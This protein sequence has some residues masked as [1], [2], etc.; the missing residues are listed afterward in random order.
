MVAIIAWLIDASRRGLLGLGTA[1]AVLAIGAATASAD[2]ASSPVS[3]DPVFQAV[4]VDGSSPSGRI[5]SFDSD[6]ITIATKEGARERLA[7]D[8]LVKL[9]REPAPPVSGWE[10]SQAVLLPEGDRL[11]RTAIGSTTETS[12]DVRSESLGK[13][14]VPLDCVLG[15]ILSTQGPSGSFDA[16]WDRILVEPRK[17]EVVWLLNGDRLEGSFLDMDDRKIHIQID[18][19][20]VEV[21]RMGVAALA[22]DPSLLNY[23]RPKGH[24]LEL[25]LNDGTRLGVSSTKLDEG[26]V[27]A[28]TRFGRPVR[29][30]LG[31]LSGVVARSGSVVYLAERAPAKAVY[32]S[33]IGPTR[34]YRADRAIDG[35]PFQLAGRTYDRGIGTQSRTLLAYRIEPGDRRFQA[36]VGVDERAGPLGNV[37]F[38]VLID[39]AEQYRSDPMTHR[40]APKPVDVDLGKGKI[41][42]LDT[43]FGHRGDVRDLADWVE[44]RII[45]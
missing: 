4:M 17:N 8:H 42:I 31:E 40:D 44:A 28:M 9:T 12:L 10:D 15:L 26:T 22:F 14:E 38:R 6:T 11:L 3:S 5:V 25:R 20:P 7:I 34:P 18:Q 16:R 13:L 30:G 21:E 1:G 43:Q 36:L 23:P 41:L 27:E 37:V 24:F 33:Y 39:G 19:K 32:T 2:P 35:Q 45:R 29:F